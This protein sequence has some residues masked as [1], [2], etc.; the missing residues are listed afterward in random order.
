M[1]SPWRRSSKKNDF[2]RPGFGEKAYPAASLTWIAAVGPFRSPRPLYQEKREKEMSIFEA[3][4]L[5]CFGAAWPMNIAKSLRMKSTKGKS[6]SFLLTIELGYVAGITHKI[7]YSQDIVLILYVI[8]FLMVATD[9]TLYFI[10]R[11][12]EKKAGLQ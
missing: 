7:L 6:L 9:L 12:R 8:N 11:S 1:V 4:M 10:Y 3:T 2:K 5:I